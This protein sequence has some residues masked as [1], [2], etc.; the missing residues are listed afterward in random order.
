MKRS[1]TKASS[2]LLPFRTLLLIAFAVGLKRLSTIYKCMLLSSQS[3]RVDSIMLQSLVMN[4]VSML[5]KVLCC[6]PLHWNTHFTFS[7]SWDFEEWHLCHK[8]FMY[9]VPTTPMYGVSVT[10][11]HEC[12]NIKSICAGVIALLSFRHVLSVDTLKHTKLLSLQDQE[13]HVS[14]WSRL[15]LL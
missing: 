6:H 7:A 10:G 14:S 12:L 11:T 13:L 15:A 4:F 5:S 1:S 2:S 9:S 8:S 3:L